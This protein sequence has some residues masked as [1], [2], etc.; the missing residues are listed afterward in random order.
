MPD[1]AGSAP[2]ISL[3]E[4]AQFLAAVKDLGEGDE[5][6]AATFNLIVEVE[7]QTAAPWADTDPFAAE[8]YLVGRGADPQAAAA[9]AAEFELQFR[10]IVVMHTGRRAESFQDI[11]TWIADHVDGAS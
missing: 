7:S 3:V 10:A 5:I 8:M 9:N 4:R 1:P 2:S 11:A 6:A